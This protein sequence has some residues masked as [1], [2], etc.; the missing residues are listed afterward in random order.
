MPEM[1]ELP[2]TVENDSREGKAEVHDRLEPHLTDRE[3]RVLREHERVIERAL[4]N[5]QEAAQS[6][7]VIWAQKLWRDTIVDGVRMR[8]FTQYCNK[9]WRIS[10]A[11]ARQWRRQAIG[12]EELA[13]E[14]G[15]R[16]K[17]LH[18]VRPVLTPM[19][20]ATGAARVAILEAWK[21]EVTKPTATERTVAL[22]VRQATIATRVVEEH[23]MPEELIDALDRSLR[24][25]LM[26]LNRPQSPV[27]F[28]EGQRS[29][30]RAAVTVLETGLRRLMRML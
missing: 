4:R 13:K 24:Q 25:V 1:T 29:Q 22:V 30:L 18:L 2:L 27:S 28:D 23:A 5:H 3:K 10:G 19:R 7:H 20:N 11:T 15:V 9:K 16:V 8:T 17:Y 26:L 14:T 12:Y 6:I 21:Q